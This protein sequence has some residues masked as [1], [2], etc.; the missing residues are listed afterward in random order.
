MQNLCD[1]PY[2]S[3]HTGWCIWCVDA[4]GDFRNIFGIFAEG[5]RSSRKPRKE[6]S[7]GDLTKGVSFVRG[8]TLQPTS[9]PARCLVSKVVKLKDVMTNSMFHNPIMF[10]KVL[11]SLETLADAI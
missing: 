11:E 4:T 8:S 9:V 3:W 10:R 2:H 7:T 6:K 1:L 5:E